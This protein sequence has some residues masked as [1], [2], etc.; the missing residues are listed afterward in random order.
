VIR[1]SGRGVAV[2]PALARQL[3]ESCALCPRALARQE[4]GDAKPLFRGREPM[5][6]VQLMPGVGWVTAEA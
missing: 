5:E 1:N 4:G 6:S 2:F 3:P